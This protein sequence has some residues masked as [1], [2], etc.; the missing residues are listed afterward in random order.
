MREQRCQAA[1]PG[2]SEEISFLLEPLD[3]AVRGSS[4]AAPAARQEEAA[5]FLPWA[6]G[7]C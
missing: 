4:P 1:V 6:P 7:A 2:P 3:E 5:G